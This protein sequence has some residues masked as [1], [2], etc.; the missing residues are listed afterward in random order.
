M[1]AYYNFSAEDPVTRRFKDYFAQWT[2]VFTL[3]DSA[4]AETIRR[5]EIDILIDLSGHT[6]GNRLLTFARKPAPVQASWM[7]YPGTTGLGAMDYY[8]AD[9]QFLPLAEFASQFTEKLVHLPANAP[10][11]PYKSA[12]AVNALPASVRGHVTFGSFNRLSKVRGSTVALWSHLLRALPDA[13]VIIGGLPEHGGAEQ[14]V[15]WFARE[16]I[17]RERLTLHA[18]SDLDTY[19][20]LH[21][22]VDICL[23][24][25]PYTG[26]TTTAHALWMGVPTLSIAGHTPAAR[27]GAALLA[28]AGLD[29]FIATDRQDFV[30]RG[31]TLA[32]DLGALAETRSGLRDRCRA[33]KAH[34]PKVIA[35]GVERAL[36]TMWQRWCDG[37]AAAPFDTDSG[38]PGQKQPTSGQ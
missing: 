9:R 18:R 31:I 10:F 19:L 4:L 24:T 11:L 37:L 33:S 15:N 16:G 2:P 36:R 23:D 26:G 25:I 38:L 1:H 20:R 8:F 3:S 28:R 29:N 7:G 6:G 5:D 30:H 27:Q 12:P 35:D 13:R 22:D 21:Q 17:D 32:T 14:L 34:D